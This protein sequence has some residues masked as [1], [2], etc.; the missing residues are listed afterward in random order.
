MSGLQIEISEQWRVRI[1]RA[2]AAILAIVAALVLAQHLHAVAHRYDSFDFFNY[3]GWWADYW[4]GSNPWTDHRGLMHGCN[5]TP[6]YVELFSPL[7]SLD[8]RTAF[9][10]WQSGQLLCVAIA[11]LLLAR[12]STPPLSAA[13]T[14]IVLS[15]MLLSRPTMGVLVW[16]ETA[17]MLLALLCASWFFSRRDRPAAAGLCLAL[18]ALIKLFPAAAGGYFLFGRRWRALGWTIGFFVAGV[19]LTNPVHWIEL[20]TQG[21]PMAYTLKGTHNGVTVLAVVRIAIAHFGGFRFSAEPLYAVWA[22]AGLIDLALMAVAAE[23]TITSD[24]RADLDGLVFGL[25]AAL[26]LMMSPIAWEVDTMLLLPAYLFGLLAASQ[27]PP[28]RERSRNAALLAGTALLV[29]CIASGLIKALA[30]PGIMLLLAAYFGAALIFRARVGPK[31][32]P[33]DAVSL[34]A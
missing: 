30:H 17:P 27:S 10:V 18:A 13:L 28:P 8:R 9:W 16:G 31:S 29:I 4:G 34:A 6:V 20:V 11:V 26:A 12:E 14:I 24:G 15:L 22:I 23:A 2:G 19:L 3:Y 1:V 7:A 32:P 21:L 33:G 25:W 5:Y